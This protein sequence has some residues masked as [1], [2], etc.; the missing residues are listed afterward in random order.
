[1]INFDEPPIND[2]IVKE[3][4]MLSEIW[5]ANVSATYQTL[6]QHWGQYGFRL[7]S[8]ATAQ[9]QTTLPDGTI[10][11]NSTIGQLQISIG[12]VWKTIAHA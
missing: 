11:F 6:N 2:V 8:L 7:P 9:L 12:G 5:R 3:D 1:M 4:G 10:A